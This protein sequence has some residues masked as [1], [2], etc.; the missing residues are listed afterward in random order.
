[1][2]A[3]DLEQLLFDLTRSADVGGSDPSDMRSRFQALREYSRLPRGRQNRAVPLDST[4]I[5]A[6]ILGLVPERPGWAGHVSLIIGALVPAGPQ[7]DAAFGA[8]SLLEA[9]SLLVAEEEVRRN[10]LGLS[11]SS[12]ESGTNTIGFATIKFRAGGHVRSTTYTSSFFHYELESEE[13]ADCDNQFSPVARVLSFNRQF[14]RRVAQEIDFLG[15]AERSLGDGSEYDAED[16]EQLRRQRLGVQ[17][18]SRYLMIGVDNQVTWPKEEKLVK[19]DRFTMVL[20]PKTDNYVQSI[21]IDLSANGLSMQDARTVVNRFLSLMTWCYDQFA[22]SQP[23]W[24]GNPVPVP[25]PRRDLAF[26]TATSWVFDRKMPTDKDVQRALALYREARNAEQNYFV[27]YAV[28]NYYKIL[29]IRHE[30]TIK[31]IEDVFPLI[32]KEIRAPVAREFHAERGSLSIGKHIVAY[33]RT[34]VAHAL[35]RTVK[36]DPDHVEE[37][38]RLHNAAEILRALARHLISTELKVS[39]SPW[40]GD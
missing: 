19:F 3:S 6:A 4:Q 2:Y 24:A 29:E 22:I 38:Y 18:H 8:S 16:A 1:M 27:S 33:Y 26:S 25:V 9:V 10:F 37:I 32:E 12:A 21:S 20:M 14:F 5:A 40:S 11:I 13:A 35:Q 36:S 7:T 17:S 28:L 23:G 39:D 34:A 30:K 15:R 31:W